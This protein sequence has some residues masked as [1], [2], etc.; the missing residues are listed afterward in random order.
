MKCQCEVDLSSSV[1]YSSRQ[2]V[3]QCCG[4]VTARHGC[5]LVATGYNVLLDIAGVFK[6]E[7]LPRHLIHNS[8]T[9]VVTQAATQFVVIHARLVLACTP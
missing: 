3:N 9:V 2:R 1:H 5:G 7:F 8:F 6:G 4:V